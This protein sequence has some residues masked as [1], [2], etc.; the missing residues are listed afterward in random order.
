MVM[1]LEK[2][3]ILITS[4]T[5]GL[6]KELD[7]VKRQLN[8]VDKEVQATTNSI[9]NAF[10]GVA[11]VLASLGIGA[12][13]KS[14]V[15]DAMKFEAAVQQIQR[16]MGSSAGAFWEWANE[17]AVAFGM[18]RSEAIRYGAVY[19]NLLSSFT[20]STEQ[21][22]QYTQDLLKASAVVA[23]STGRTME[24]TMERIR[25]G[26]LGNTEAI[27]DLGINV[28]IA[29]IEST[30][31]FQR[32]ANGKSWD[33]LDFRT[34]QTIRYF[35]ILEQAAQKYGTTLIS[36]TA[37]RQAMFI[38]QLKD[39]Q[40]ALGQAFLPIYNA[41]LPALTSMAAALANV[42]RYIAAFM[43]ALFGVPKSTKAQTNAT[44]VQTNAI[45]TQTQ[46]AKNQAAAI[47]NVG[48]AY[49]KAGQKAKKAAKEA[50]GSLAGF[51]EINNIKISSSDTGRGSGGSQG[52]GGAGGGIGGGADAP[53]S[54]PIFDAAQS[55][56]ALEKVSKKVQEFANK[57]KRFFRPIAKAFKEAWEEVSQYFK[58]KIKE[59]TEFWQKYGGQFVQ[60]LKNIW[61][62]LEPIVLWL[63][64]FVWDSIKG[65]IDGVIQFFEGLIKFI[66]GVFTG[67]WKTAFDGLKDMVIGAFKVV[68][69]FFNLTLL[70]G[71]K[72]GVLAL[73]KNVIQKPF[74]SLSKFFKDTGEK[75]A[76]GI[77]KPF[78]N[79][80]RWFDDNVLKKI[81][82][83]INDAKSAVAQKADNIWNAI[84]QKFKDAYTWFVN[85]VAKKPMEAFNNW[86]TSIANAALNV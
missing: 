40:L 84:K 9:K 2:L 68:W 37:T 73:V 28:N 4:E 43:Q 79:A 70:G 44:K 10:R 41:V 56:T 64:E 52:S 15:Q 63:I 32:F 14:A 74:S 49:Q 50:Q 48:N 33:Q 86:K 35:A 5:S 83:A 46:A 25:S 57:V 60:A 58:S 39:A 65:L 23:S 12:A 38:A 81:I 19:A 6:R 53:A 77:Q 8:S 16:L 71:I 29:M 80:Y 45:M 1:T 61:S 75:M 22:M 21:T 36:N 62:F 34:Q 26:L 55:E 13:V 59:L 78:I 20:T 67:D 51:D 69:N 7:N 18:A 11:T 31:A 47:N 3:Q 30:K 42:M 54:T 82:N 66:A 17:N 85:N 27:E 76:D 24:D 72:K